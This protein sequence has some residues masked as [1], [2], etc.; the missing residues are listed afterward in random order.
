M[1]VNQNIEKIKDD[2]DL[3]VTAAVN[4]LLM[5]IAVFFVA[6]HFIKTMF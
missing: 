2:F 4:L 1:E 5:M 6:E 3:A